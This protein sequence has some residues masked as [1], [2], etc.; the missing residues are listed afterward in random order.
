MLEDAHSLHLNAGL[1]TLAVNDCGGLGRTCI[2]ALASALPSLT[3]LEIGVQC[4]CVS[5]VT[6]RHNIGSQWSS[7]LR[8]KIA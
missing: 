7:G 8:V 5:L 2:A 6:F 3:H 1:M 4:P